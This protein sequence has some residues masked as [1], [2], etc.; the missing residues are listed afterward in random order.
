MSE[1][2]RQV[3]VLDGNGQAALSVVRSLGRKGVRV[4]VGS[5]V[6]RSLGSFS[7]YADRRWVALDPEAG[8]R[9]YVDALRDHLA[10]GDYFA[11]FPIHDETTTLLSKHKDE[12]S[13]TGT[14]IA[15]EDWET[16][17]RV[18]NKARL[19]DI[20]EPLSIP[21]PATYAPA[22]V[23][24]CAALADD[25]SYPVVVKPRS[26][27]AWDDD[28][29][30]HHYRVSADNYADSPDALLDTVETMVADDPL[31][32]ERPPIVQ[33]YVEG[34]TVTVVGLADAGE[35]K[36]HFQ[37]ERVRTTPPE[38]GNSTLLRALADPD[39][40]AHAEEVIEDL[41]WTGPFMVEFMRTPAGEPYLIEVNGRY[42]GSLPFTVESGVDLP[43]LHYA[44]LRGYPVERPRSYRTDFYQHR[45]LYEDVEWL[46]AKL[47]A[48]EW[49]AIPEFVRTLATA[50]QTFVSLEDPLPT[51]AALG[52]TIAIG[53][54]AV[55]RKLRGSGTQPE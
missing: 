31:L 3:L 36:A 50:R 33:E 22:S 14:V 27:T 4:T 13:A 25:V 55:A 1:N 9:A 32:A 54:R 29:R 21:T 41:D 10:A 38:G 20:A 35:I 24:E 47:D 53:T 19:F 30:L 51:L 2:D 40:T 7:K 42:W 34:T 49:S 12:L 8:A 18:Y 26:K 23:E 5:H 43:W 48:G 17:E 39:L 6:S 28:G 44:Q 52:Q 37:E 15:A 16:Y 45:L 11:V 46:C